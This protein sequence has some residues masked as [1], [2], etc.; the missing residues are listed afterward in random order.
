MAASM[1]NVLT[2]TAISALKNI[3]S[4]WRTVRIT[5]I[6]SSQFFQ[7]FCG[8]MHTLLCLFLS[9]FGG[10]ETSKDKNFTKIVGMM[11]KYRSYIHCATLAQVQTNFSFWRTTPNLLISTLWSSLY[12]LSA[13]GGSETYR[14][15]KISPSYCIN[16]SMMSSR[17]FWAYFTANNQSRI[18]LWPRPEP[19]RPPSSLETIKALLI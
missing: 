19:C 18:Q 15:I 17:Q 7:Y 4:H 6:T 14:K 16:V 13:F 1:Y 9:V 10:W 11:L 2:C 8:H 3:C 5:G 12:S